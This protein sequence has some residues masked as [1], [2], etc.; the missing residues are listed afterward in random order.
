MHIEKA[1]KLVHTMTDDE[2]QRYAQLCEIEIL[3]YKES[4]KNYTPDQMLRHGIPYI[5]TVKDNKA[6][7]L[8]E[9][10]TRKKNE[11]QQS[12]VRTSR[13]GFGG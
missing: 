7:F 10:E 5:Q 3:N 6:T 12:E 2:L 9:L 13:W 1:V 11:K 4:I 8:H